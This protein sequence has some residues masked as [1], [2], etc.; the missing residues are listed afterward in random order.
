MARPIRGLTEARGYSTQD[1]SLSCFGGAGGQHASAIASTLNIHNVIVHKYSSVLSAY[2]MALADVAVDLSEPSSETFN[3]GALERILPKVNALKVKALSQLEYQGVLEDNIYYEVYLNLRYLGSDTSMMIMEPK[4]GDFARQF[5]DEHRREFSFNL[6]KPLIVDDIR[7]RGV[8]KSPELQGAGS[9]NFAKDLQTLSRKPVQSDQ[10]FAVQ[11]MYF[12]EIKGWVDAPVYRLGDLEPGTEVQGPSL[13]LDNTQTL[14]VHPTNTAII[15]NDHVY[16]DV[17]LGPKKQIDTKTIDPILLSV[18]GSRFMSIAEQMG[19]TLQ[20]TSISL[21][22]KERLDFSCA[23]FDGNGDLIANAPAVPVHL[24]AMSYAVSFQAKIFEGRLKP[25]D[26]IVSNMPTAGGSHLP[27]ITVICPVFQDGEIVFWTAARAHHGD[28]GGLYGN[29]MPPESTELV[30]E[31][32]RIYAHLLVS[33]GKF[34]EEGIKE[35]FEEAGNYPN[36]LAARRFQDNLS[37]LKAQVSACAVGSAKIQDLFQEYSKDVVLF[38]M[39]GIRLNAEIA[40]RA[41]L[42][43]VHKARN[44]KPLQAID[45]MDDGTPINLTITINPADGGAIFDFEGTGPEGYHNLNA[46]SAVAKSAILYCLRC[47][48]GIDIPLNSGCLAPLDVQIPPGTIISPSEHVACS[49]GNTETSQRVTDVVFKAFEATAASQGCMNV[50]QAN[51]KDLAYGETICGG[52]G[53]GKTWVGTSGVHINMTNT[54]MTDAEI[55]EKRF[56]VILRKFG[57]REGSGGAGMNKGGDGVHREFEFIVPTSVSRY[58]MRP[59][60]TCTDIVPITG[61]CHRRE[62]SQCSIWN[63]RRYARRSRLCVL[64]AQESRWHIKE[65]QA[66]AFANYQCIKRRKTYYSHAWRRW[67]RYSPIC[68]SCRCQ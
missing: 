21:Q 41:F 6:D 57:I 28:I 5:K 17:G 44:G 50:F 24:G 1:H 37:D 11:K 48:I 9:A 12:P 3:D 27:D 15:L 42:Q 2:G 13:V 56:P 46:P 8:G 62:T 39:K 61:R 10:A 4:D 7:V 67:L 36:C 60:S 49:S 63:A 58:T 52:H 53:A 33:D 19:R 26:I 47:L 14:V 35:I 55:F 65:N 45:Y 22:I 31:G 16:I 20:K 25:G 64:D 30:Q 29:S 40:V 23:V 51:Y 68:R 34:D 38:Y 54:K 18:F 32:A 59:P 43:Q 66:Q